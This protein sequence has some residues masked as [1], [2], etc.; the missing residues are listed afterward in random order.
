[1]KQNSRHDQTDPRDISTNQAEY[2]RPKGSII[3]SIRQE[4]S[5]ILI[6]L[7]ER[8][9][10]QHLKRTL[11]TDRRLLQTPAPRMVEI[12]EEHHG[13]RFSPPGNHLHRP[14]HHASIA[15]VPP[16]AGYHV[17]RGRHHARLDLADCPGER[18]PVQEDALALQG[19]DFEL[20]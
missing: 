18:A 16:R 5:R 14:E 8:P 11:G 20:G 13:L 1:M 17:F 4:E 2:R 19:V 3:T 9:Q 15:K 10:P 6:T 12:L 7:L